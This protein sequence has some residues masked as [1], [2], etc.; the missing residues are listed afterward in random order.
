MG[1]SFGFSLVILFL[2]FDYARP[3]DFVPAIGLFRPNMILTLLMLFA[4]SRSGNLSRA[5]SRQLT[6]MYVLLALIFVH[7]PFATNHY[8]AYLV[9]E[10]FLLLIP[11]CISVI[12]Y[13]D[14]PDRIVS[15]M[16][17]WVL[18]A[19]FVAIKSILHPGGESGS[20]FLADPNDVGLLVDMMLPFVLCMFVYEKKRLYKVAYLVISLLCIAAIVSTSSRGGLIGLAAVMLVVW[21][22]SPRKVLILTLTGI[23]ALGTYQFAGQKYVE[24]MSTINDTDEGTAKGRIDSW[25]AAWHMFLDHPLGV[26]PGNFPIL[27]PRYMVT[28]QRNMWGR[29]A[30]SLWFTL[31]P[32]LGIPGVILYLLIFRANLLSIRNL[33]KMPGDADHPR[34]PFLLSIA[35]IASIAGFFGAGTFISVLFYPHYWFVTAMIVAAEK[36]LAPAAAGP[37]APPLADQTGL[38]DTTHTAAAEQAPNVA[39]LPASGPERASTL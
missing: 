35:F 37:D 15:F 28:G 33:Y 29:A 17:W 25:K 5:S 26:G 13:V 24:R 20:S 19:L 36:A 11:F 14:T 38:S 31:L 4:W 39:A 8:W 7:I 22:W 10:E 32:E 21:W 18:L 16:R 9:F 12:L 3:Q 27:F 2:V 30:H 6:L 34:L 1:N 23:L